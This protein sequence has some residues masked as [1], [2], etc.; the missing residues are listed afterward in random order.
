MNVN[1]R[2][3]AGNYRK[4]C[5][6]I[7]GILLRIAVPTKNKLL[8]IDCLHVLHGGPFDQVEGYFLKIGRKRGKQLVVIIPDL[9]AVSAE[10]APDYIQVID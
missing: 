9:L 1:G 4:L 8:I 10:I 7:A 3:S 6:Y 2:E 5:L